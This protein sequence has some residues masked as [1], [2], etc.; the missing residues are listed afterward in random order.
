[1]KA[2]TFKKPKLPSIGPKRK[3]LPS[4]TKAPDPLKGVK[5]PEDV[6]E[7]PAVELD[8]VQQGFRERAAQEAQRFEDATDTG[9]YTCL[10]A[11][12]REQL[13]AFLL[14][15]G[16]LNKGDLFLDLREVAAALKI[17]LPKADSRGGSVAKIDK[18]FARMARD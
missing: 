15:I 9:Y 17:D 3:P 7:A 12:N 1:M 6:E 16:M 10:V 8:A 18:T 14:A 5:L 11:E 2:P 4:L 13:E